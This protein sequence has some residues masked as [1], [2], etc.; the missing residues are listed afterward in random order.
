MTQLSLSFPAPGERVVRIALHAW[1][2]APEMAR[3]DLT[4]PR[5]DVSIQWSKRGEFVVA[6][7]EIATAQTLAGLAEALGIEV[8]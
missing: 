6:H 3:A 2:S 4:N 5:G 1:E 8:V 7:V